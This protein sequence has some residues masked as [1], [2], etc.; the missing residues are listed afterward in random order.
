MTPKTK[1]AEATSAQSPIGRSVRPGLI[2]HTEFHSTDPSA[3]RKWCQDILDWTFAEPMPTPMGP[4]HMW[5]FAND[6]GGG[7]V[8]TTSPQ[9]PPV[10]PYCEVGDIKTKFREALEAGA[11]EIRAPEELPNAQGW[12]AIV[13]APGGVPIGFWGPA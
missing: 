13:R 12:I 10:I 11:A 8:A 4:Y 1:R 9:D 6:T 5:S 3:T 7:L 2:S